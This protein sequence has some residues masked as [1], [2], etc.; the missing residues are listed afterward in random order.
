MSKKKT[1]R[2]L[3]LTGCVVAGLGAFSACGEKPHTHSYGYDEIEWQWN[4]DYTRATATV[5]CDDCD[6][7]QDGHV[8]T[9]TA[10]G[11]SIQ[12]T[13][14]AAQPGQAGSVTYVAKVTIEGTQYSSEP[15]TFT[16]KYEV[17]VPTLAGGTYTGEAQSASVPEDAPYTVTSNAQ[18]AVDAGSYDVTLTLKDPVNNKWA[19]T[20]EASVTVK[21]TIAKAEVAVPTLAGGTYTGEAQS[22]SVPEDAPYTITSN[23]QNAVNAGSYDVTL[24]L[25]DP[26]NNKWATTDEASVTVKY[27]IAKAENSVTLSDVAAIHCHETP[28]TNATAAFGEITYVYATSEDGEYGAVSAFEEGTYYVK[29][30]VTG[31]DNYDGAQ[32]SAKSFTVTH[33]YNGWNTDDAE[34]DYASCA[35]GAIDR[36]QSFKKTVDLARQEVILEGGAGAQAVS[37]TGVSAYDRVEN[38]ALGSISLGTDLANLVVS[39]ELKAA[40]Q[41]H[42]EQNLTVTVKA[43]EGTHTVQVPVLIVTKIITT[44]GEVA[45]LQYTDA[46]TGVYGY[47]RLGGN[48]AMT[49]NSYYKE[50]VSGYFSFEALGFGGTLDGANYTITA[51]TRTFG[52]FVLLRNATVK[53]LTVQDAW[54]YGGAAQ[55][56]LVAKAA[57]NTTFEN[58]NFEIKGASGSANSNTG[59]GIGWLINSFCDGCTFRNVTVQSNGRVLPSLFGEKFTATNTLENVTVYAAGLVEV[60]HDRGT[61]PVTVYTVNDL[62]GIALYVNDTLAQQTVSLKNETATLDLGENYADATVESIKY[63]E[64]DLGTSLTLTL[65]DCFTEA[66]VGVV[67]LTIKVKIGNNENYTITLPVEIQT[68]YQTAALETRKEIIL[69][70]DTYSLDLG[71]DG[72]INGLKEGRTVLS[73]TYKGELISVA[74]GVYKERRTVVLNGGDP[75]DFDLDIGIAYNASSKTRT[76]TQNSALVRTLTLTDGSDPGGLISVTCGGKEIPL[77][78]CSLSCGVL[79]VA[80][81]AFG[82]EL[83]GEQTL[84]AETE[85][86]EE[87]STF[88]GTLLLITKTVRTKAELETA[89]TCQWQGDT[90]FGYYVFGGD[91]SCAGYAMA[92]P[93]ATDWNE[94]HG[95]RGTL[96]GRG[97]KLKNYKCSQYGMTAQIGS[98]AVVKNIVF[99]DAVYL[100]GTNTLIARGILKATI[101]NITVTLS[102]ASTPDVGT[103]TNNIFDGGLLA[104]ES[105]HGNTF[106]GITLNAAGMTIASL[107]GKTQNDS[108]Y[109]NVNVYAAAVIR[110]CRDG[111]DAPEGVVLHVTEQIGK[112]G[113]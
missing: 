28:V 32:S 42:G 14:V 11:N 76:Y 34:Y 66:D 83:Y 102:S 72:K 103:V 69:S 52:I 41:S 3:L 19:T 110:Y 10:E 25:K 44:P 112:S 105:S 55:E 95:F 35:C 73:T 22:A 61:D 33:L 51:K 40:T 74:I 109:E 78:E 82:T 84:V 104:S 46:A 49:D 113:A 80:A 54:Y 99:E 17:A 101:E 4:A 37:I 18:N 39:D 12:K 47:Y 63:G 6:E 65:A 59:D 87:I 53:N 26:V 92:S 13:E 29:A 106:R 50:Y 62:T 89:I 31:T 81:K 23:A 79:S 36:T 98:G 90:I 91:I 60:G 8:L 70:A 75:L 27:T 94:T 5:V 21:Y 1:L 20:D 68:A 30:V 67:T 2:T 64:R 85:T 43:G 77:S 88:T 7:T 15:V 58:V 24:T 45:A 93:W 108:A 57:Y 111:S 86:A 107:F 9:V 48:I 71:A 16:V 56:A 96:D 100:G 97:Y 38:V